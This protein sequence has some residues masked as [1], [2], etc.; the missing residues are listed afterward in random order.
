MIERDFE[1]LILQL[2]PPKDWDHRPGV[3]MFSLYGTWDGAQASCMLVNT[4]PTVPHLLPLD[5]LIFF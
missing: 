1:L 3:T 5:Q 4:R 2:L